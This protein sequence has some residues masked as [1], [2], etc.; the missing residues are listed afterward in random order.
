MRLCACQFIPYNK[1][2]ILNN[3]FEMKPAKRQHAES[4]SLFHDSESK[5]IANYLTFFESMRVLSC[6]YHFD[7]DEIFEIIN[8]FDCKKIAVFCR[9]GGKHDCNTRE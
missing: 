8:R 9:K 7:G 2:G 5:Q 3:I 6:C 4:K 1:C